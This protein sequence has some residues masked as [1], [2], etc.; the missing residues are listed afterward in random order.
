MTDLRLKLASTLPALKLQIATPHLQCRTTPFFPGSVVEGAG[1]DITS[2]GGVFTVSWNA[3]EAGF[4]AFGMQLGAATNAATARTLLEAATREVFSVKDFGAVGD[5]VT[6][7]TA[8]I[9]AAINAAEAFT[10]ASPP[11]IIGA[12]GNIWASVYMPKGNYLVSGLTMTGPIR[13][14]GDGQTHS[15]LKLKNGANTSVITHTLSVAWFASVF[16]DNFSIDCNGANQASFSC[17]IILSAAVGY[18]PGCQI[19][20]MQIHNAR[21]SGLFIGDNRNAGIVSNALFF[22]CGFG[23][24]TAGVANYGFDWRFYSVDIGE[25]GYGYQQAAQG[26]TQ[27]W[28]TNFYSNSH[29]GVIINAATTS[30]MFFTGCS[31]DT[32]QEQ[33]VYIDG[34]SQLDTA[35][36]FVQCH[37]TRNGASANN[38]YPD[39]F[40]I[41]GHGVAVSESTFRYLGTP[42]PKYLIE[43]SGTCGA[44]M[45]QGNHYQTSGTTPWATALTNDFTKIVLAGDREAQILKESDGAFRFN[46]SI[47]LPNTGLHLFDTNASHDLIIAPGSDL[48]ADRTLSLVTGDAARTVTLNGNPT[49]NDWF[50]QSVKQAASPTF[51][52]GTLT[53]TLSVNGTSEFFKVLEGNETENGA[54]PGPYI[55]LRRVSASPAAADRLGVLA[56][57]GKDSA[58]NDHGYAAIEC[59]IVDPTHT[60]EDGELNFQATVGG[61]PNVNVLKAGN[62][63]QIGAPTGGYPGLGAI[64]AESSIK[65]TGPTGGI[66]YATGAGGTVTQ[67]TSKATGVTLNKIT[68]QITM[69][70]ASLAANTTVSFVLTNSAIAAGDTLILNHIS[71]GTAGSYTLNARSASGSATI[72]VRNV[73]AGAL[74]E[75]IVIAFAVI[76]AVTS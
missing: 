6:D 58:G 5:G 69:D 40:V 16:F 48:T 33:G 63:V 42:K 10:V 9:Q 11:T 12:A 53:G 52:G 13:F 47:T 15:F 21:D 46:T 62:G 50:D 27:F 20:N 31:I 60:S 76:K 3:I 68:G 73:T 18:N 8:A 30:Y 65:S 2:I 24:F 57:D 67:I 26:S 17:G 22:R 4:S 55:V 34:N 36:S 54:N 72:D 45:W 70:A 38:I 66:G 25:C 75:A 23:T 28:S 19:R 29:A 49:L 41:N 43:F 59:A 14:F 39:I 56:F 44:V 32:N 35:Y 64:A 51:A 37:F 61:A 71:G 7:D 74:A 1:I